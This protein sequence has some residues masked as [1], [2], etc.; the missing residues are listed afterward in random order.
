[1]SAFTKYFRRSLVNFTPE[2]QASRGAMAAGQEKVKDWMNLM[3]SKA[4]NPES[5]AYVA[6]LNSLL[7][8]Y[9]RPTL[10]DEG[11]KINWDSWKGKIQTEGFV[12]KIRQNCESLQEE[13]YNI[14]N[15]T[16]S[17]IS[18]PSK[19]F[20]DISNE[21]LFHAT[22]WVACYA[23]YQ[24][25]LYEVSD[26]GN[27]ADYLMHENYDFFDGLE[28][29][30]EELVE[31]NNYIPGSKDDVNLAG[32]YMAQFNWGKKVVSFYRHPADDFK[33]GKATK[34]ILGR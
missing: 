24:M 19:E 5:R 16:N 21:L 4:T 15:V 33:G 20:E 18:V 2:R 30:L 6:Q 13:S 3:S 8:F 29:E 28:A 27:V 32:Y 31:T 22:M 1:M 25:F 9:I 7:G 11:E 17:I 26:Y 14:E 34:N 12:D 23:D 10:F